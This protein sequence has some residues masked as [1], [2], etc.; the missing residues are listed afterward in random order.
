MTVTDTVIAGFHT[1][2]STLEGLRKS[3]IYLQLK[4]VFTEDG[5]QAEDL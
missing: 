5:N 3:Y 4:T 1:L 2:F